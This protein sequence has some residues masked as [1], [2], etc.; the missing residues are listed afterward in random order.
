MLSTAGL[1]YVRIDGS[2]TGQKRIEAVATF[3]AGEADVFLG[4][5][6]AACTSI[7]LTRGWRSVAVDHSWKATNYD[8]ALARTARRGQE[9]ECHHYDLVANPLQGRIVDRV[10]Q[11]MQFDASVAEW[12]AGK[13]VLET[14]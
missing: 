3:Q 12:Q 5:M 8:Q 14:L 10:R 11:G 4:Q 13:A 9:N 1:T 6:D 2:V 7:E